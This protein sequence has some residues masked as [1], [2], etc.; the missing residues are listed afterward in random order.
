MT[1][2]SLA[3]ASSKWS[4][5]SW[6]LVLGQISCGPRGAFDWLPLCWTPAL[7]DTALDTEEMKAAVDIIALQLLPVQNRTP[8]AYGPAS[9]EF[10]NICFDVCHPSASLCRPPHASTTL[11][12]PFSATASTPPDGDWG[13]AWGAVEAACR[14]L[15][16]G[17]RVWGGSCG[18]HPP[19]APSQ[20]PTAV[21]H[22]PTAIVQ[23]P[24]AVGHPPRLERGRQQFSVFACSS[25]LP[26]R[27]HAPPVNCRDEAQGT[28]AK[29]LAEVM[30]GM[31]RQGRASPPPLCP[32]VGTGSP[33]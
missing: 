31:T 29:T 32:L 8:E 14:G 11:S 10:W 5:C 13:A 20:P 30:S 33:A 25:G 17:W 23:P 12:P 27:K 26:W 15:R 24:T 28:T 19:H 16:G 3:H 7:L 6:A 22:P 1:D 18:T 2:P 9:R 21:A 4:R